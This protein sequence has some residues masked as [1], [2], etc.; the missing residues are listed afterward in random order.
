MFIGDV[1]IPIVGEIIETQAADVDEI[2]PLPQYNNEIDHVGVKHEPS[3]T[4]ITFT[5][6][7]NKLIHS[8]EYTLSQQKQEVKSLRRSNVEQNPIDYLFYK[9]HLV[10][11]NVDLTDNADS[12]I[13]NEAEIEARYLPWP[14]FYPES[15]P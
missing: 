9:G 8:Q 12:V 10:I 14:K 15:E 2:S 11:Q 4:T 1:E 6:Y 7:L 5:V 13:I 3:V